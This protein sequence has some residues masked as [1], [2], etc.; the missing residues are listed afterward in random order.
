MLH[1]WYEL[2]RNPQEGSSQCSQVSRKTHAQ[3]ACSFWR[4][5]PASFSNNSYLALYIDVAIQL[6]NGWTGV[7]LFPSI[8]YV[9]HHRI[10]TK[11]SLIGFSHLEILVR[12]VQPRD[13]FSLRFDTASFTAYLPC[14]QVS[15]DVE[16]SLNLMSKNGLHQL[17]QTGDIQ[18][19]FFTI[20]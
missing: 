4:H 15:N 14:K 6:P 17:P 10:S 20:N 8:E 11:I 9:T 1:G 7:L 3:G 18:R 16:L 5:I 13:W 2:E 19:G 12:L